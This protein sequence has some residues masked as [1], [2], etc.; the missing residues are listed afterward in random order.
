MKLYLFSL[1]FFLSNGFFRLED[2]DEEAEGPDSD[3]LEDMLRVGIELL[4]KLYLS[5]GIKV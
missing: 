1:H 5:F 3:T 2:D 4:L